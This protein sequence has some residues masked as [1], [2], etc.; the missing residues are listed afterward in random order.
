MLPIYVR[1]AWRRSVINLS[2]IDIVGN[3]VKCWMTVRV[4]VVRWRCS[5]GHVAAGAPWH[6]D[7]ACQ[8]SGKNVKCSTPAGAGGGGDSRGG[9]GGGG[10]R[11]QFATC[12]CVELV[13]TRSASALV[14]VV[15]WRSNICPYSS[16][17]WCSRVGAVIMRCR[18]PARTGSEPRS[19]KGTV[20]VVRV[21]RS[22]RRRRRGL[23]SSVSPRRGSGSRVQLR[24]GSGCGPRPLCVAHEYF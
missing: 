16:V 7:G 8:F 23:P 15:K 5:R 24:V 11:G 6:G 10:R 4:W 22:L 20:V 3:C 12:A 21:R 14:C 2:L 13:A 17:Y 1:M 19:G 18:G 9:G